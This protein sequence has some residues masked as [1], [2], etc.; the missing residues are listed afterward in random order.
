[1]GVAGSY[2]K[3]NSSDLQVQ[4]HKS[5]VEKSFNEKSEKSRKYDVYKYTY[6]IVQ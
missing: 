4:N 6:M 3:N 2:S 5:V 1:M